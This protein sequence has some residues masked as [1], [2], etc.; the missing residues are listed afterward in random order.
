VIDDAVPGA[1]DPLDGSTVRLAG[2][3]WILTENADVARQPFAG[4]VSISPGRDS[5]SSYQLSFG[6]AIIGVDS[7]ASRQRDQRDWPNVA[8]WLYT[9]SRPAR[10]K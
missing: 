2:I 8:T 10:T 3:A 6:D 5:L 7:R 4:T 9:F 1:L